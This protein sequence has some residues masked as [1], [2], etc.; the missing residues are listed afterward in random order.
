MSCNFKSFVVFFKFLTCLLI[1]RSFGN[2]I[3][4]IAVKYH[5]HINIVDLGKLE[6]ISIRSRKAELDLNFLRNSLLSKED[7]DFKKSKRFCEHCERMVS[8]RTY[9]RHKRMKTTHTQGK[10]VLLKVTG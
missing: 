8:T 1:S 5:D 2:I 4:D 9:N 3:H 10:S 6:K 7:T